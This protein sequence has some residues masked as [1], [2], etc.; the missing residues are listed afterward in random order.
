M[1]IWK[2]IEGTN[3]KV[4]NYGRVKT[5]ERTV[6][7]GDRIKN[8][9]KEHIL[10]SRKHC[11]YIGVCL[12]INGKTVFRN[13]HRLV[14]IAFVPNPNNYRCVNHIDGNKENNHSTNLEWCNHSQN[15]R[16]AYKNG[17]RRKW[18]IRKLTI[19]QIKQIRMLYSEKVS[20]FH[21]AKKF[22]IAKSSVYKIIHSNKSIYYD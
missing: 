11:G 21:I 19:E 7:C 8:H 3:Y 16:H 10:Y 1:E 17:L 15:I 18:R 14:A 22:G 9:I 6:C 13:I 20:S 5:N 4:S 2:E 12:R